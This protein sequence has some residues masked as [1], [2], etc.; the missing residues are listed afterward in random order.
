MEQERQQAME[1]Q[2]QMQMNELSGKLANAPMMDPS[3]N[4]ELANSLQEQIPNN[5]EDDPAIETEEGG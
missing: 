5:N 4:P 3:K 2:Q 1:Q